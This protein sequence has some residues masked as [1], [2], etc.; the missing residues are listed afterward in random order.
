MLEGLLYHATNEYFS[1]RFQIGLIEED[2]EQLVDLIKGQRTMANLMFDIHYWMN[3]NARVR[4]VRIG[5]EH[6]RT[7][8]TLASIGQS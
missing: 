8:H 3:R 1:S 6:N 7:A 2:S 5:R 4:V